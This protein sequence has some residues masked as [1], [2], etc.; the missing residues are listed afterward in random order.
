MNF[1]AEQIDLL[2][3]GPWISGSDYLDDVI[4]ALATLKDSSETIPNQKKA[5]EFLVTHLKSYRKSVQDHTVPFEFFDYRNNP[6]TR[7]SILYD[8]DYFIDVEKFK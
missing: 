5:L 3:R 7:E 8:D 2:N 4:K 6:P 1:I